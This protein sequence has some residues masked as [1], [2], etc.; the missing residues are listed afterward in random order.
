MK[1]LLYVTMMSCLFTVGMAFTA[2]DN[3]LS[4]AVP[5]DPERVAQIW[6]DQSSI[7]LEL[8][9]HEQI[10]YLEGMIDGLR[11][12]K[13]ELEADILGLENALSHSQQDQG[14]LSWQ[15]QEATA[16]LNR[17]RAEINRLERRHADLAEKYSRAC[18]DLRKKDQ[19][20][21]NQRQ[22]HARTLQAYDDISRRDA[23]T[24][25]RHFGVGCIVG[26]VLAY[27]SAQAFQSI[28]RGCSIQ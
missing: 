6:G 22:A 2:Q 12:R 26:A 14:N 17:A 5:L 27:G 11:N 7:N 21:A 8:K 24:G 3:Q 9:L 23:Q 15:L 28:T 4:A 10:T 25:A 20:L 1:K 16:N 18:Y 19:E 13:R